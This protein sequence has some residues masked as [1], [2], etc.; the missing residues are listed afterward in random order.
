MLDGIDELGQEIANEF[1]AV[2]CIG[3]LSHHEIPVGHRG[4][5]AWRIEDQAWADAAQA[6]KGVI[7]AGFP[8]LFMLYGRNTNADSLITTIQHEVEHV[9]R[10]IQR[11]ADEGLAWIDVKP[12]AMA[13]DNTKLQQD[14]AQIEPWQA[15]CNDYYRSPSGR[16]FT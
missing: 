8:N 10:Q 1:G 5:R 12:P 14:I 3:R 15:G 4:V 7:T 11:L 9:V 16:L 2:L 6:Y 13:D